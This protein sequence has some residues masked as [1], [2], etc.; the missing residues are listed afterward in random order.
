MLISGL[1][2]VL[3]QLEIQVGNCYLNILKTPKLDY[4]EKRDSY[5]FY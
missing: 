4:S 3:H 2:E 1:N 5:Q